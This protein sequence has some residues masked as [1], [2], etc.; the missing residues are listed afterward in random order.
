M[1]VKGEKV[2]GL[3]L[4]PI[5]FASSIA[6]LDLSLVFFSWLDF[7]ALWKIISLPRSCILCLRVPW[8]RTEPTPMTMKDCM[9]RVI[10]RSLYE[11]RFKYPANPIATSARLDVLFQNL[12][13]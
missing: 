13:T 8:K 9:S 2:N 1:S 7:V 3:T 4:V 5:P 10:L 12:I 6:Y 11:A